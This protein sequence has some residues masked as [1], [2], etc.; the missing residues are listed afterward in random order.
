MKSIN[1]RGQLLA[2]NEPKIMGILNYTPD[3]FSDGGK[4]NSTKNAISHIER[5]FEEGANLIDIGA[6]SSRPGS[7]LLSTDE[8]KQRLKPL[9]TEVQKNFPDQIFSLDTFRSEIAEWAVNDYNISII[10]DIS[11]GNLDDNMFS[12][13]GKLQVPYIMMHMQGTPE[14]M[15]VAP[16]YKNITQD[17][18][19]YFAKKVHQLSAFAVND[20]IIDPGFGFGKTLEDNY[21]LFKFLDNFKI[22]EKL[23]LVGVSRKSMIQ[24]LLNTDAEGSLNGTSVLN[25]IALTKG[26]NMLRVHDVKEAKETLEIWN[27]AK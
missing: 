24:K 23:L 7:D 13:I 12:T 16:Q 9:L 1:C 5:M 25:T 22:L 18:I 26:A 11:A 17:L 27:R 20:I 6:V 3:S 8:E 4:Y 2:F 14:D 10:N 21:E 19:E 15:Q